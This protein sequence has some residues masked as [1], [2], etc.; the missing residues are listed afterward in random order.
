MHNG[1][2]LDI[3]P[4]PMPQNIHNMMRRTLSAAEFASFV[5]VQMFSVT[6]L[7]DG[8]RIKGFLALPP[9]NQSGMYPGL[10]FNRGGT[11]ERG[12]LTA[13]SAFA[14]AGLYASW[15][16]VTVA[17]NY[18]GHGGSEG[19]EE[20]GGHDVDDAMNCIE[21]LRGLGY[22]D[23]NRV[24][25]IGGSRGGMMAY[26][27]LRQTNI[28][29]AAVTIGAPT[30]LHTTDNHAYIRKTFAK[31]VPHDIDITDE[32]KKRSVVVWANE[33]CPTTPLLITHGTGD[34]RV[35]AEHS[36]ML[37]LELQKNFHP[38]RLIMYENADHI[39]AGRRTESNNDI[40]W[41]VDT[42]VRDSAPLPKTGLHG[43]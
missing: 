31:F 37:A 15:G 28:F 40:R 22:V 26:M 9:A 20:W 13:E 29:K 27:M 35:L 34:K 16:Y 39:L 38:Y 1:Q 7:S 25:L 32:L 43:A 14:Y 41:W 11:G 17:S 23:M 36:L 3:Q 21:L 19:T 18:R 24:G 8:L 2:L 5:G 10:I 33:L 6:Y 12:A 4:V 30:M 42:F